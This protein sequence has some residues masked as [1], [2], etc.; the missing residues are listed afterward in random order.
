MT[1]GNFLFLCVYDMYIKRNSCN[2]EYGSQGV[3]A[4]DLLNSQVQPLRA[5]VFATP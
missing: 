3:V 5:R 4:N 2:L 1:A